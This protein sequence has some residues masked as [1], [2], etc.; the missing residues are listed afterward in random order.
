MNKIEKITVMVDIKLKFPNLSISIKPAKIAKPRGEIKA[1]VLTKLTYALCVSN[2]EFGFLAVV[3][4][5]GIEGYKDKVTCKFT[6]E[7]LDLK[8][9][10]VVFYKTPD[11]QGRYTRILRTD[12]DAKFY[13]GSPI[14]YMTTCPNH[15]YSGHLVKRNNCYEFDI[16]EYMGSLKQF[17]YLLDCDVNNVKKVQ[18]EKIE[19][20]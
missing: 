20:E 13:P 8:G 5:K 9:K 11:K 4:T 12:V 1:K 3:N 6:E 17:G 16:T 14:T 15:V 7:S 2:E 18:N 19:L 10:P